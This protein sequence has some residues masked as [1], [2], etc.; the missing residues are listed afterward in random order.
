MSTTACDSVQLTAKA[1]ERSNEDEILLGLAKNLSLEVKEFLKTLDIQPTKA[2]TET[3]TEQATVSNFYIWCQL[4]G[5]IPYRQPLQL[6]IEVLFKKPKELIPIADIQMYLKKDGKPYSIYARHENEFASEQAVIT[7]AFSKSDTTRQVE[8]VAHEDIHEVFS[9]H[10][11]GIVNESFTT[12]LGYLVTLEF[13]KNKG[14][15]DNA[16][17]TEIYIDVLVNRSLELNELAWR[18]VNLFSNNPSLDNARKQAKKLVGDYPTYKQWYE[19][20]QSSKDLDLN[21]NE[22]QISHDLAYFRYF[23]KIVTL[24]KLIGNLKTMVNELKNISANISDPKEVEEYL[25]LI[26]SRYKNK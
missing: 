9:N 6:C 11:W 10:N 8:V 1:T 18:L 26:E 25:N 17:K 19:S 12:A 16:Q 20:N 14:D 4:Y 22:A 23:D 24:Y 21:I 15:L 2:L 13:F 3:S 5:T 7:V